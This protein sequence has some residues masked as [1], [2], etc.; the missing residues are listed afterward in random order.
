MLY[1]QNSQQLVEHRNFL[2]FSPLPL[3]VEVHVYRTNFSSNTVEMLMP[4]GDTIFWL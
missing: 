4:S 2:S 1:S 3:V